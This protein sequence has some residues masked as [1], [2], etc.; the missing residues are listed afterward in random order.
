MDD[1]KEIIELQ[2]NGPGRVRQAVVP[3]QKKAKPKSRTSLRNERALDKSENRAA[4]KKRI[5]WKLL[6]I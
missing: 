4:T 1:M 3:M 6:L 2:K 5:G